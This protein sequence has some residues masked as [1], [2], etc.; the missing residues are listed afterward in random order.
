MAGVG[1]RT[2]YRDAGVD[3]DRYEQ[4]LAGLTP[5]IDLPV[6]IGTHHVRMKSGSLERQFTITATMTPLTFNADFSQ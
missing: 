5:L 6:E 2:T 3:L 4:T 1:R